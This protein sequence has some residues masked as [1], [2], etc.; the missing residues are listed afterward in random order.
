MYGVTR[1]TWRVGRYF[2]WFSLER[3]ASVG[4]LPFINH[5]IGLHAVL[6][7]NTIEQALHAIAGQNEQ[8]QEESHEII[9]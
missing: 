2:V 6:T 8:Y 3:K 4:W 7:A 1:D 9:A 5:R